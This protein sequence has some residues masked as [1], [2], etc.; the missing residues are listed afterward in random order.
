MGAGRG[1][2]PP[3]EKAWNPP[4][5]V[6]IARGHR[7]KPW[8]PPSDDTMSG[9]GRSHRWYVLPSMIWAPVDATSSAVRPFQVPPP[10]R[11]FKVDSSVPSGCKVGRR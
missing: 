10:V 3:S 5:S 8:S 2:L 7:V 1:R 4:E 6:S 9:P 11:T